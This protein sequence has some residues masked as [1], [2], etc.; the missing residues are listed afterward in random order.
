MRWR[1]SSLYHPDFTSECRICGTSPTVVVDGH[2]QGET[3]LC[4]ICFFG[5]RA[6]IEWE[7]WDDEE[8]PTE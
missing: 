6:M 7:L 1:I 8:E 4:G 5:D 3:L 2:P